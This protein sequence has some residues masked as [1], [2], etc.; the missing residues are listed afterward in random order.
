MRYKQTRV[1]ELKVEMVM[2][3]CKKQS[4]DCRKGNEEHREDEHFWEDEASS[5]EGG[6]FGWLQDISDGTEDLQ[7]G[8]DLQPSN[9]MERGWTV[10]NL[11]TVVHH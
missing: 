1:T 4:F 8:L 10:G 5:D 7:L 2:R 6:V 3:G 9:K 11:D